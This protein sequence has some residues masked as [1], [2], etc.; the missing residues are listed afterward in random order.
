[1]KNKIF[2]SIW[3]YWVVLTV[4]YL[5]FNIMGYPNNASV[6][7]PM[8]HVAGA[9]GLFVPFGLLS[10]FY[11]LEPEA[12]LSIPVF[13]G[14]MFYVDKKLKEKNY[15]FIKS[16]LISLLVLLIITTLVDFA[17]MTPFASWH[18]FIKGGTKIVF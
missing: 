15:G 5:T 6:G 2:Q 11:L 10:L 9:I 4:I 16:L 12:W 7:Q 17:R 3:F 18:I 1:M 8:G 14:S 13:F